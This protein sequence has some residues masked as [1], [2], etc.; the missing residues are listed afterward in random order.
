MAF[1]ARLNAASAEA[2]SEF[3]KLPYCKD[4]ADSHGN[5]LT[6]EDKETSGKSEHESK[7][8]LEAV[9]EYL[10]DLFDANCMDEYKRLDAI[11]QLAMD[12]FDGHGVCHCPL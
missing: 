12:A 10:F 1:S 5:D 3:R 7:R 4:A 9:S 8:C 11:D 6:A 2:K